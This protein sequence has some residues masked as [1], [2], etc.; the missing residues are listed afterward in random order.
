MT[1]TLKEAFERNEAFGANLHDSNTQKRAQCKINYPKFFLDF[2]QLIIFAEKSLERTWLLTELFTLFTLVRSCFITHTTFI[3]GP[4]SL[5]THV[6]N[7]RRHK[8][9]ENFPTYENSQGKEM[10][11][12]TNEYQPLVRKITSSNLTASQFFISSFSK[13][14]FSK[15]CGKNFQS[16]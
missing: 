16:G 9:L 7:S 14:F 1:L 15:F 13:L 8:S 3:E 11:F 12:A 5:L 6:H 10:F 2:F 4:K